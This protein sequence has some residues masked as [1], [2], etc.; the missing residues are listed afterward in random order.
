MRRFLIL[1]FFLIS[2]SS[3]AQVTISGKIT[4]N[5][6]DALPGISISI[7]NSYD[8]ATSDSLGNFSFTTLEKGEHI[9][10]ATD[11]GYKP[12]EQKINIGAEPLK[13]NLS[14]KEQI[15]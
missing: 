1:I 6:K 13:L 11:T 2:I 9:L 4:G 8:G 7:Q 15:T 12:F 3:M 5:R 14:L 10:S